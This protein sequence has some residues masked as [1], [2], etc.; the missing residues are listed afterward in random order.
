[1]S[2]KRHK[3]AKS[4]LSAMILTCVALV[5]IY[6]F[7]WMFFSSFKT[8]QEIYQSSQ[9]LP[10]SKSFIQARQVAIQDD[11]KVKNRAQS[12]REK[13]KIRAQIKELE[14][15]QQR[16]P[17]PEQAQALRDL[18]QDLITLDQVA[19]TPRKNKVPVQEEESFWSII[20]NLD[21]QYFDILLKSNS[22]HLEKLERKIQ[23]ETNEQEKARYQAEYD[24]LA[25]YQYFDFR[26]VFTNSLLVALL[27][28]FGAVTLSATAGYVFAKIDFKGKKFFFTLAILVI[29]IPK[30]SLI[31]PLFEWINF[32]GLSNSHAGIVLPGALNAIGLLFFTQIWKQVPDD[33]L[34]ICRLEGASELRT[35]VHALPLISSALLSFA[36]LDF[37]MSW[38]EHLLPLI[39]LQSPDKQTLPLA[40]SQLMGASLGEP[41]AVIMAGATFTILPTLTL[42]ALLYRRI[43]SSLADLHLH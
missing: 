1:M 33:L 28:C 27:H 21:F 17:K 20:S 29:L 10:Q 15:L 39:V 40:L 37:I 35:F 34:D 22:R 2:W 42:F 3:R 5:F 36:L 19:Q 31:L 32:I 25:Q 26:K 6:P 14:A 38:N 8:N 11:K 13:R 18:E 12:F 43:K 30:Q 4:Y 24:H 9:L 16:S 7:I 23:A 41:L